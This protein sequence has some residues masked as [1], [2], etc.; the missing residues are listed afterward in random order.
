MH[1]CCQNSMPAIS[2]IA[3]HTGIVSTL[4]PPQTINII[5]LLR[6]FESSRLPYVYQ[7]F[8]ALLESA[9]RSLSCAHYIYEH[10]YL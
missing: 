9:P 8:S 5:G 7:K 4:T 6:V 3:H 2:I 10:C 1:G